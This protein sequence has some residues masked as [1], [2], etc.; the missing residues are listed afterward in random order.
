MSIDF[1]EIIQQAEHAVTGIKD[2]ALKTVAFGKVID[3]LMAG[4]TKPVVKQKKHVGRQRMPNSAA[5][6]GTSGF[7][8][9][10]VD[11]DYFR[12]QHALA[13]VKE[14]LAN[15]GHHVP[16]TS[17]SGPMQSLCRRRVL[18]REKKK[19]GSKQTYVYSNW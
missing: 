6:M 12:S 1:Q 10:M 9:E 11:Q 8:Q 2:P 16:L 14:E 13:D 17:L 15:R 19:V 5:R 3:A 18:R 7:L 4:G